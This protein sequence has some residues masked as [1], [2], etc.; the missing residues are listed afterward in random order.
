LEQ[1]VERLAHVLPVEHIFILTSESQ[2]EDC[3]RVLP[4]FQP[5]QFIIEP[6][7]RDTAPACALGSALIHRI[8]PEAT[9]AF[10]A[11]DAVVKNSNIYSSQ[12]L[13]AFL[14]AA[15]SQQFVTIGIRPTSPSTRFGYLEVGEVHPYSNLKCTFYKVNSFVEKPDE[16][17]ARLLLAEEK[18]LWNAGVFLWTTAA[19]KREAELLN[20]P[21]GQFFNDLVAQPEDYR[22]WLKE[23]F[24]KLEKKSI[25]Y[26]I[27]EKCSSLLVGE[28]R[29]DWDDVGSWTALPTHLPPDANGNTLQGEVVCY[30]SSRNIVLAQSSLIALCGVSDLVVVETPDAI[31]VCHRDAAEQ[32][33]SL[34]LLLPDRVK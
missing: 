32:I 22:P 17:K 7:K 28:A 16:K 30:S 29:F 21:L 34:Q 13:Q 23:V 2:V 33:K 3:K 18:Y 31:L 8:D 19:F 6:S 4:Q 26:A 24:P 20:P 27:I 25:D 12:L 11:A 15:K 1:T 14:V 9:V 5:H 10:V